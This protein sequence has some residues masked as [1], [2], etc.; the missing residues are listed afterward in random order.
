MQQKTDTYGFRRYNLLS[1]DGISLLDGKDL[2]DREY[3]QQ[4]IKGEAC[5]SEPL[6]SAVTGEV[7]VIVA[8]HGY[9]GRL[10]FQLVSTIIVPYISSWLLGL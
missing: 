7:T 3:F 10:I 9:F 5:V 4:A 2:S 1:A 8:A 6:V